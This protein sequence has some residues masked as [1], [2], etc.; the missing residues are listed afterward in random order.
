[1]MPLIGTQR[2]RPGNNSGPT[3]D[4][5]I[6]AMDLFYLLKI[7]KDTAYTSLN[8]GLLN[9]NWKPSQVSQSLHY[10]E[11]STVSDHRGHPTSLSPAAPLPHC[12]VVCVEPVAAVQLASPPSWLTAWVWDSDVLNCPHVNLP[13]N[14]NQSHITSSSFS[15]SAARII[16]RI[17]ESL[18]QGRGLT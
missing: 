4:G 15:L 7:A 14:T 16:D 10:R 12:V 13:I 8:A 17:G 18:A 6:N 11:C 3:Q 2:L 5:W 1:M 9:C